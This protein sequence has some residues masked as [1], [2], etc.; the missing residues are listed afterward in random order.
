KS[1]LSSS[2]LRFRLLFG[3][4]RRRQFGVAGPRWQPPGRA[5]EPPSPGSAAASAALAREHPQRPEPAVGPALGHGQD[6]PT[7]VD[8]RDPGSDGLPHERAAGEVA[9][10]AKPPL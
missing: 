8:D 2:L 4:L 7:R 10:V 5:A 1:V 6:L 9:P 3:F